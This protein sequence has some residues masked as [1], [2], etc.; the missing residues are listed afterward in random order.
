MEGVVNHVRQHWA[1]EGAEVSSTGK[2][3]VTVAMPHEFRQ[4][5][6][7]MRE[8]TEA[9]PVTVDLEL[10]STGANLHIQQ[11]RFNPSTR[12]SVAHAIPIAQS[13]FTASHVVQFVVCICVIAECFRRWTIA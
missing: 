12:H 11:V 2:C 7:C 5:D 13:Y 9:F 1:S 3:S 8:L 4:I 10:T 6:E